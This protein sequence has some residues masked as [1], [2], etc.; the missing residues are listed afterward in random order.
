MHS[1]FRRTVDRPF[2]VNKG[3]VPIN[4]VVKCNRTTPAHQFT[5]FR[6]YSRY[7]HV[8][9]FAN[10]TTLP[11]LTSVNLQQ[12]VCLAAMLL[13]KL[14][15]TKMGKSRMARCS[16]LLSGSRLIAVCNVDICGWIRVTD[17]QSHNSLRKI[18]VINRWVMEVWLNK[19]LQLCIPE[20]HKSLCESNKLI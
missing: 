16:N 2:F 12:Q 3:V 9:I 15:R 8:V 17:G 14:R 19:C 5:I 18:T 6:H 20:W 1:V 7:F 11:F 13:L 10:I 4:K